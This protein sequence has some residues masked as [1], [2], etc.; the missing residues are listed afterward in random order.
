M[1]LLPIIILLVVLPLICY[2]NY[3][4]VYSDKYEYYLPIEDGF[5]SRKLDKWVMALTFAFFGSV[6]ITILYYMYVC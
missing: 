1:I 5:D 3:K 4:D 6:L 2:A